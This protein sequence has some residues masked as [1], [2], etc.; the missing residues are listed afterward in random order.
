MSLALVCMS[1]SPLLEAGEP[2]ESVVDDIEGAFSTARSFV[3]QFDPELVISFAPDHYNGFFYELMPQFCIGYEARGVGDFGSSTEPYSVPA[4][5]AAEM[6]AAVLDSGVEAAISRR[7]RVDHGAVQP[8]EVLFGSPAAHQAVVPVFVN[9][10]APP[11][12]PMHRVRLL[13]EAVGRFAATLDKRVLLIGSGGLS[14]DPPVAQWDSATEEQKE[15]LLA[16]HDL[17]PL[18]RAARE[19]R[20]K[21]AGLAFARGDADI[22]DLNPTWDKEFLEV[23]AGGK[24][25]VF[26]DYNAKDMAQ[27]AG[28]SSHE[29]RTWVAAFSALAAGAGDYKVTSTYYRAIPEL[30]AGFAVMTALPA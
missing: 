29:V 13:G 19:K 11:F 5:I 17:A 8:L 1:H 16:G 10:A 20:V 30:I 21:D 4:E 15:M 22:Q 9:S 3:E 24:T 26:D 25:T 14:H 2:P 12:A 18:A 28:K 23:C 27:A 7:M 6:A